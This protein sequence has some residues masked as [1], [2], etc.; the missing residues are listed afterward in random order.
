MGFHRVMME[1]NIAYGQIRTNMQEPTVA[2]MSIADE[3]FV[4]KS[5]TKVSAICE[6]LSKN[7]TNA[8]LVM[9]KDEILG[10]V[11]AKDIFACMA[12]G[13]NASKIKVDKI[14]RTNIMTLNEDTP[15][16]SALEI[17]SSQKPDSIVIVDSSNQYIGY[18]STGDYREA[19]R[20]LE[21]HQ[22]MSVR[23][24]RSRKAISKTVE[25]DEPAADLLDLL[26]GDF[27]DDEEE[28]EKELPSI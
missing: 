13:V 10:V 19:T 21:A 1:S 4:V 26:L 15:I 3:H 12:S 24:K 23:L 18:F 17:M 5:K 16:S 14:M 8:V 28:E 11:T 20:K 25:E 22:L 7:P 27:E 2:D 9:K 6:E